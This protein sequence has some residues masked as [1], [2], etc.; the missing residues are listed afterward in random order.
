MLHSK[1]NNANVPEAKI[2]VKS[3]ALFLVWVTVLDHVSASI[4]L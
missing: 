4:F 1:A 2:K 3:I